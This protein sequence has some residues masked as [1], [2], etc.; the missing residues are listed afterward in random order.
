MN[1]TKIEDYKLGK[2]LGQGGFAMVREA[3][4]KATGHSVA[5]KVYDKYKM[6]SQS[7]IRECIE[8]EVRS[9]TRLMNYS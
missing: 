3:I 8:K 9:L 5:M 1:Y 7:Y 6:L 2:M 4:H